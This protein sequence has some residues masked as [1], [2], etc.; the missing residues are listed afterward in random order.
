MSALYAFPVFNMFAV[1]PSHL[2]EYIVATVLIIL[3]PGPSVLFTIARAI[4]WGPM[5][6]VATVVGNGIGMYLISIFVA[7]GLGPVLQ[8]SH[9]AFQAV[10]WF[11]GIYLMYLGYSAIKESTAHAEDMT[12]TTSAKPSF[13][14]TMREGFVVGILN[15]K[16]IVFFAA[17]LP[18]FTEPSK[19]HLTAQL[20]LLGTIFSIIAIISDSTY[21]I[22]AGAIRNWLSSDIKRLVRLRVAGG[23]VMIFLGLFTLANS[24]R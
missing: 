3:A 11:G 15:P 17:I 4:A 19:G 18:Q 23:G 7:I 5:I 13:V 14:K 10:Q 1:I 21:G 6:A 20:I 24:F 22:V 12:T 9:L 8:Q 16:S 2:W